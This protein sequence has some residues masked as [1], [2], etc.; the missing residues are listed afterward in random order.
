MGCFSAALS[1]FLCIIAA[2]LTVDC[3]SPQLEQYVESYQKTWMRT[4]VRHLY[5]ICQRVT[6][7]LLWYGRALLGMKVR[8]RYGGTVDYL[9]VYPIK[10]VSTGL[11]VEE[12][13]L[14]HYGLKHDRQYVICKY[15]TI[16]ECYMPILL[17]EVPKLSSVHVSLG[18]GSFKF[19]YH[20]TATDEKAVFYLPMNVTDDY[21]E[22]HSSF[23]TELK[24]ISLWLATLQGYIL[25]KALDPEFI[26][27]MG[28]PKEAVLVYSP[29]GKACKVGAPKNVDR[30]T[31]FHDYYP[32]LMTSQESYE[33]VKRN[34]GEKGKY[35]RM[36]AFR[37]NLVIRDVDKPFAEDFYHKFDIVG[38]DS[39]I[40]FTGAL[41][42]IRC[43]IP[44]IDVSNGTMDKHGTI[45]KTMSNYRRVDEA[46]PYKSCFGMY[47]IQH[48][49]NFVIRKGDKLD[50]L[51]K[52]AMKMDENP[53]Y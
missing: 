45:S 24:P 21:V 4:S 35:V 41:K 52:K 50:I 14:D 3:F 33:E 6:G 36:E 29:N 51:Q 5:N 37:P 12:W 1:I 2:I 40:R 18:D 27:S 48:E 23:G 38:K 16:K 22:Q 44:N 11:K 20:S 19:E 49:K 47:V 25:D 53:F 17:K 10:A 43:T 8:G 30:K 39:R 46:N 42:C 26:A 9:L 28:L 34:A 32:M 31:L 13:E 15:D 7:A